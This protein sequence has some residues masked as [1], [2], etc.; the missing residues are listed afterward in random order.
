MHV[1]DDDRYDEVLAQM[2]SVASYALTGSII[3]QDRE[4]VAHAMHALR[5]AAGNFYIND[6][7]TGAVVGQQ[8]F[9]GARASGTN[10]KAGAP[11]N[12][13]RWTSTRA[14]KRRSCR[15]RTTPTPTWDEHVRGPV[16]GPRL[17][18]A[19][20][21]AAHRRM[22]PGRVASG[23]GLRLRTP[24]ISDLAALDATDR[25]IMTA[26]IAGTGICHLVTAASLRPAAPGGRAILAAGGAFTVLVAVFPLPAGGGS[27]Q[28]HSAVALAAFVALSTWP[29]AS[30]PHSSAS[31]T[32]T[33]E[34]ATDAEVPWGLRGPVAISAGV[35]LVGLLVGFGASLAPGTGVASPNASSR[36]PSRCGPSPSCSPSPVAAPTPPTTWV[37][38]G[39][40]PSVTPRHPGR[41]LPTVGRQIFD[42]ST[43]VSRVLVE[44]SPTCSTG[45][46]G[47]R[48]RP[49]SP[50][51][52]TIFL[53]ARILFAALFLLSAFGHF[54]NAEAMAQYAAYK[55]APGGKLG[56][57]ASGAIMGLGALSILFGVW[58]DIGS[59]LIVAALL[60]VTFFMHAFWKET[61]AQAKQTEQIAFNKNLAL[62]GGAFAFFLIFA[63]TSAHVGL[64]VTGSLINLS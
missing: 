61:D 48:P 60:P 16:V 2:E 57:Y 3:A 24:T 27:S 26:G 64:T 28:A 8:P 52:N 50:P 6:K 15:P 41:G 7:S 13:L 33:S 19:R 62:I 10:D 63:I 32:S 39:L 35:V 5:F 55:K 46:P 44:H 36:E 17:V 40:P 54:A 59:L 22:D 51:V 11:Q 34:R 29:L 12:L 49:G 30:T 9:G 25:W 1:Y 43:N 45:S 56:V 38:W 4:A 31:A 18:G 20:A 53:I 58:G 47:S 42:S 14:I 23:R 37:S 21:G